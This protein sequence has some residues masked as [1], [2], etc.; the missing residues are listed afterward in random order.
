MIIHQNYS[1][2]ITLMH[3]YILVKNKSEN[4]LF[5]MLESYNSLHFGLSI[6]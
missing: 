1:Y 3:F 5:A 6:L 2:V 4:F